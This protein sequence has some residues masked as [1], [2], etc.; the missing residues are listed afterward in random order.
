[1]AITPKTKI[2][3]LQLQ[4][5]AHLRRKPWAEEMAQQLRKLATVAEDLDSVLSNYSSSQ[6]LKTPVPEELTSLTSTG[7]TC[8]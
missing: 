6:P 5:E 7:S 4:T 3:A 8:T 2:F 1:M